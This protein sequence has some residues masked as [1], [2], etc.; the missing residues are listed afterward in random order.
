NKLSVKVSAPRMNVGLDGILKATLQ[1]VVAL[2]SAGGISAACYA[3]TARPERV[4]KR[5]KDSLNRPI[6]PALRKL[7]SLAC[8]TSSANLIDQMVWTPSPW[9][10]R[11]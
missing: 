3:H 1:P 11:T 4:R 8:A 5:E 10:R 2:T 7:K 9:Q 6:S